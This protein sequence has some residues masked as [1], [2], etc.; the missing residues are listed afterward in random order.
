[1]TESSTA[2]MNGHVDEAASEAAL[3]EVLR[4][5]VARGLAEAATTGPTGGAARA[6]LVDELITAALDG[7]ARQQ[8]RDGHPPLTAQAEARV[9]RRMRHALVGLGGLQPLL[10][11][12]DIE[13]INIDGCDNVWAVYRDGTKARLDPIAGSDAELQAQLRQMGAQLG[14]HER[15]FDEGY[16]ELSMQLPGGGR[17][18]ALMSV[19]DRTCVSIRLHPPGRVTLADQVARGEMTPGMA[20]LFAAMVRAR[21]NLAVVGGPAVGKTT[22]LKALTD[23]IPSRERIITVEDAYELALSKADHPD[24]VAMQTRLPNIEGVGGIDMNALLRS[25]LRMSPDRVIVGE[26]RGA[27]V[28]WM[29]KAMSIGIDG[30]MTTVHCSDSASAALRM[31]AY[32]MEPPAMYPLP[33][34]VALV[35]GAV[36]FVIHLTLAADGVRVVSS[37]REIVGHDGDRVVSNEIYRPGPHGRAVPGAPLRSATLDRLV[38]VGFDPDDLHDKW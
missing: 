17:L 35:A 38:A 2:R 25:C 34:A 1:M 16:P 10:D 11:D 24:L 37:V 8:L 20:R 29:L 23:A 30:S 26:V 31:I 18:H 19:T 14:V 6:A 12:P 4:R 13:T 21:A 7:H 15:R 5:V 3:A 32:A 9:A 36:H 22:L 27:E 33:A 28:V